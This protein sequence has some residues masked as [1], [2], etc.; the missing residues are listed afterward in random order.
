MR[1]QSAK[2]IEAPKPEFYDLQADP[3]ELKNL[4]TPQSANAQSPRGTQ[5]EL[6][7]EMAKWKAKLPAP[8]AGAQPAANLP[9]PKDKIEVQ[10]LLHDSMLASDDGRTSDS[11]HYLEKAIQIDPDSSTAL[12]QLGE[13]ELAAQDYPKAATHLK[14]ALQLRP[15][16]STA[17]FEAGEALEKS[18]DF[19]GARDALEASLKLAPGQMNAR[20]LLGRVYLRLNDARNAEDQ[21]EAALLVDSDNIEGTPGPG[22]SSN[23][24]GRLRR[25]RAR[26]RATY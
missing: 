7:A 5:A 9:D 13:L 4:Y 14:R 12:R 18:G 22:R 15:D 11:L 17:A 8:P 10:N 24:E 16:D 2:F 23:H 21:F 1:E 20:L 6:E 25:R 19:A 26:L 3:R